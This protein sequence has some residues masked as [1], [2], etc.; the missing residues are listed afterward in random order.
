MEARIALAGVPAAGVP[1]HIHMRVIPDPMP[2][3]FCYPHSVHGLIYLDPVG[4]LEG[5]LCV[6]PGSHRNPR[7]DLDGSYEPHPDEVRL[8]FDPGDCILLHGNLWHRT[9]PTAPNCGRRG[10]LLF[11]YAPSWLKNDLARGVKTDGSLTEQLRAS[12]DPE[13]VELLDGFHW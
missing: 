2:P 3:F 9:V 1:W 11:G 5:P 13:L 7:L 12:G 4:E 6:V 10:L 8:T